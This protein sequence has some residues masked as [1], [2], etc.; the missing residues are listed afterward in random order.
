MHRTAPLCALCRRKQY[1]IACLGKAYTATRWQEWCVPLLPNMMIGN[2]AST[3]RLVQMDLEHFLGNQARC[4]NTVS[5]IG[6]GFD[7][8]TTACE[9][10]HSVYAAYEQ[11]CVPPYPSNCTVVI[12]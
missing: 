7:I 2:A 10:W 12:L 9:C 8:G 4:I 3:M 1:A 5:R 11:K 6:A